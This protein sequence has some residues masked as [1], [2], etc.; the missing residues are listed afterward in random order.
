MADEQ[1]DSSQMTDGERYRA[2][3][4][5]YVKDKD[6]LVMQRQAPG[7]LAGVIEALPAEKLRQSPAPGKWSIGQILAH[8]AEAELVSSWRYRQMVE[9]SGAPLSA[10]DQ[11][12]WARLG[13]YDARDPKESLELFRLLREA[14]LRLFANLTPEEWQ[15]FSMH[16]ERG[17]MTVRDLAIQVAGHDMSH[18]EQVRQISAGS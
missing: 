15:R 6:P 11:A 14:N 10:F 4:M 12:E 18:M 17:R 3:L 16:A 13:A 2:R 7:M 1:A 5:G 8:L 9:N